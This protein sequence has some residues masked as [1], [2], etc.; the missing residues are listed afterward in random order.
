MGEARWEGRNA[1]RRVCY[2]VGLCGKWGSAALEA[3][4]QSSAGQTELLPTGSTPLGVGKQV[5]G[6]R[7]MNFRHP[8]L[9]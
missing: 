6:P 5:G 3:P 1:H 9:T 2:Q 8:L 4:E 7:G